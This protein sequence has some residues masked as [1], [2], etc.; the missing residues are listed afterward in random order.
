VS[1]LCVS[2]GAYAPLRGQTSYATTLVECSESVAQMW[3]LNQLD[4]RVLE[5]RNEAVDL[6]LDVRFAASDDATPIVLFDPH[7]LYN[8]Q[9]SVL[10]GDAAGS[11]KLAPLHAPTKCLTEADGSLILLPCEQGLDAQSFRRTA[12]R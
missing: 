2:Q 7:L 8:Q 1:E 9:F 3:A 5:I 6:N 12:C 11:F 10:E 4:D